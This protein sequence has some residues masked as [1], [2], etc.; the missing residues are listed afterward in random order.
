MQ[1]CLSAHAAS[2]NDLKAEPW[3]PTRLLDR[4]ASGGSLDSVRLAITF[5]EPPSHNDR[6]ATLSHCWGSAPVL[7]LKKATCNDFREG[8]ELSKLPKTFREAIQ[9][10]RRLGVRFL[11]MDSLCIFQDRDD[12]SDWLNEADLMHK[13]YSHSF[14][15]HL[16][17]GSPRQFQGPIFRAEPET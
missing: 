11:W 6:Y 10:T 16:C 14:L 1:A 9:V 7:E 2:N 3:Y 8:T 5:E 12:L 13:V 17:V 15:Q 4:K